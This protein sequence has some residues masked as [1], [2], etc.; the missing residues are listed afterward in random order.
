M[1]ASWLIRR[2]S[3]RSDY[4]FV[5][6]CWSTPIINASGLIWGLQK[7]STLRKLVLQSLV[8]ECC[9]TL[10][11]N[12]LQKYHFILQPGKDL[13]HQQGAAILAASL[14]NWIWNITESSLAA[15]R[16]FP[17][18]L[19]IIFVSLLQGFFAY[20]WEYLGKNANCDIELLSSP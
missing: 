15:L 10:C 20:F 17:R 9:K 16:T 19:W 13:P 18:L 1:K 14:S 8:V 4:S 2:K 12:R 7:Q 6:N 3:G 11:M 5:C